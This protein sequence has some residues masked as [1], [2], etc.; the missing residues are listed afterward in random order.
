MNFLMPALALVDPQAWAGFAPYLMPTLIAGALFVVVLM[1]NHRD[2]RSGPAEP[3]PAPPLPPAAQP[4][5]RSAAVAG[6]ADAPPR[7]AAAAAHPAP[8][9]PLLLV[10]DDSAVVRAKLRKLFEGAGCDVVLAND[11]QQALALLDTAFF[12]VLVTDL[13]MP[14]MS[15]VELIA[16][17]RGS[18]ETEDL[19]IIAITGHESLQAQVRDCEGLYG[20]FRK[21]WND[22]EL[23]R[24]V[25]SL[26]HLRVRPEAVPG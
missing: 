15:G 1:T 9:R 6:P 14:N 2:D 8:E 13:E 16:S 10:V 11:G 20:L 3:K 23:L 4:L 5:A 18:L 19:P 25:E 21:P 12:S 17:V 7:P 22:R 26:R 24:R